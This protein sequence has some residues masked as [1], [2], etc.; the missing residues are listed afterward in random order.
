[1]VKG[2]SRNEKFGI[3]E[4]QDR[5]LGTGLLLAIEENEQQE[6]EVSLM[7]YPIL[8]FL[9][10][11]LCLWQAGREKG[12]Q[13][14]AGRMMEQ[15]AAIYPS[16]NKIPFLPQG[17]LAEEMGKSSGNSDDPNKSFGS[18]LGTRRQKF[19]QYDIGAVHE[20]ST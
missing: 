9:A 15:P 20:R 11:A 16:A 17:R 2:K 12:R 19:L 8:T 5:F 6:Q 3:G 13:E 10:F 1:M 14:A 7:L 18:V 4:K